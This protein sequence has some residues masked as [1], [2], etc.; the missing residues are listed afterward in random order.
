MP[1][2]TEEV[3]SWWRDGS[4]HRAP[5]PAADELPRSRPTTRGVPGG[6]RVLGEIRKAKSTAKRSMRTEVDARR[7]CTRRP[8][9]SRALEPALDDVRD[10]GRVVGDLELVEADE[11]V[12][13]RR[14]SSIPE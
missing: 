3:W 2:V 11:L 4:I 10:A 1:F 14:R 5:W 7:R 8:S 9:C 13:R 6:G 12:G